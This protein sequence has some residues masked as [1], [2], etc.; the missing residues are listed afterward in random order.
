MNSILDSFIATTNHEYNAYLD[1]QFKEALRTTAVPPIKG[2]V[3]AAKIKW[4]GIRMVT[5][6]SSGETWLEQRG[7]RITPKYKLELVH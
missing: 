4:R 3:T 6:M 5:D 1:Q 2:T 7:R